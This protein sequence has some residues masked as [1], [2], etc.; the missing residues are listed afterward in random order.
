MGTRQWIPQ[1]LSLLAAELGSTGPA[2]RPC[3]D[4]K[5]GQ[6]EGI[7]HRC[8]GSVDG[9]LPRAVPPQYIVETDGPI[10]N[11]VCTVD[12][13]LGRREGRPMATAKSYQPCSIYRPN[14]LHFACSCCDSRGEC[15]QTGHKTSTG[16]FG[17][18]VMTSCA[19]RSFIRYRTCQ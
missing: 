15:G 6:F 17:D 3:N 16:A 11:N 5:N 8:G 19:T 13:N 12:A 2:L 18:Q 9:V 7:G 1:W 14:R 4:R 10:S